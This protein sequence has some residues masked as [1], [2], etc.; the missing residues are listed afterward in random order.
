MPK[1]LSITDPNYN[2]EFPT[3]VRFQDPHD[4]TS[5]GGIAY[6][7]EIICGCC[8]TTYSVPTVLK[9]RFTAIEVLSWSD[10]SN[11]IKGEDID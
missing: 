6:G 2:F 7:R 11:T 5:L 4:G 9:P 8:G 10:I 3:M 1:H